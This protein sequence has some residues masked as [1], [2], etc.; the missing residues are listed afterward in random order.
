M[1]IETELIDKQFFYNDDDMKSLNSETTMK[2]SKIINQCFY[3]V[4]E[5]NISNK[6]KQIPYYSNFFSIIEEYKQ[7]NVS[8][9]N[10]DIIEKIK[11]ADNIK[12]YLFKYNDKK[13]ITFV[14]F[15]YGSTQIKKLIFDMINTFIYILRS[16]YILNDNGVCFL[17][18]SP[19]NIIFLY[20][21][22]EKPVLNNFQL[23][24]NL[25]TLDYNYFSQIL[26]KINDFTYMPIEIHVLFY[27][28]KHNLITLS[29]SFIEELSEY[30]VNNLNILKLFSENYKKSYKLQCIEFLKKYINISSKDIV[31]D[32]FK[33][34]NKWD[35]FS[36]SM[37]Y[38]QIFGSISRIFSLKGS[39]IS[40]I[41][42]ELSK[43]LHPN[44]D[45]RYS[46]NETL[47]I[48]NKLLNEQND[49]S[50]VNNLDNNKLPQLFDDFST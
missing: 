26:N 23:S 21:Y 14:D 36:I 48:F 5:V 35:V 33:K 27:I 28:I 39:F 32:L 2:R 4:N 44:P 38:I 20:G 41:T 34:N 17:N 49:W 12:Y 15:I 42:I 16:L 7:L 10:E 47:N 31:N 43:N 11:S 29:Y 1:N 37:L 45:K 3:A 25:S 6:I 50:F 46:L 24:L 30:Y 40:R 9:L 8:Q 18:I 22:R 13:S 19:T